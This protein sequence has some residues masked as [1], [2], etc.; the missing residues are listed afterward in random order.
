MKVWFITGT[1]RGFGKIWTQAALERGDKVVATAR[2]LAPLDDLVAKFGDSILPLKLDVTDK[3]AVEAAVQQAHDHFGRLDVIVNNAGYGHM[4][5]FE[6][7]TEAEIRAQFETNVFGPIWVT[8]AALPILRAQGS[9]HIIQV[10]SLSGLTASGGMGLYSGSKWALEGMTEA[11]SQEVRKFGIKVTLI[12]P[13]GYAT[14]FGTAGRRN[15]EI[16]PAYVESHEKL[17]KLLATSAGSNADNSVQALMTVVDAE[18]PPLRLLLGNQ[19]VDVLHSFYE[20]RLNDFRAWED[21]SR[22]AD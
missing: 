7:L 9:G 2:D 4:G 11:L 20:R 16:H 13:G 14:G 8:Q 22:S 15:S 19:A 17:G 18:K 3:A 5:Y 21:V 10:S 12:E 6:E 1:S